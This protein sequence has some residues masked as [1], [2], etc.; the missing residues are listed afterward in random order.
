MCIYKVLIIY[1]NGPLFNELVGFWEKLLKIEISVKI[2]NIFLTY[3][4]IYYTKCTQIIILY[5]KYILRGYTS[6]NGIAVRNSGT[7]RE[8]FITN[9]KISKS[10]S[11]KGKCRDI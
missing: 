7:S 6:L 8:Q 3:K 4:L 2:N 1:W 5:Y 10:L 11:T 9:N